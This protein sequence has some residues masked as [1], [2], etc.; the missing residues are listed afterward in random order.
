MA[1]SS[2]VTELPSQFP[3]VTYSLFLV[4][5][6]ANYATPTLAAVANAA[7]GWSASFNYTSFAGTAAPHSMPLIPEFGVWG[8]PE[9]ST[10]ALAG[11]GS[12]TLFLFRRRIQ[13]G[14]A[15]DSTN[16]H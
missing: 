1:R 16:N 2:T 5:W 13:A 12:L 10:L 7:V 15:S 9:P 6:D 11:L 3:D 14:G 4:G 8:I